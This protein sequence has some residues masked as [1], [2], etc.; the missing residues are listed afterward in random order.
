MVLLLLL[1]PLLLLQHQSIMVTVRQL[2]FTWA[3]KLSLPGHA[4]SHLQTASHRPCPLRSAK[5]VLNLSLID[6][7]HSP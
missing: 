7:C 4:N 3:D 2:T 6:D 5:S 1:L